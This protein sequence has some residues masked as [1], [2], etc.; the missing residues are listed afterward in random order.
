RNI[1][2]E[3]RWAEGRYERLPGLAADLVGHRVAVIAATGGLVTA[4]AAKAATTTIPV[5]FIAGFDPVFE[6]LVMSIA[7]PGGNATGVSIY[8][9]ELGRKRLE[10]LREI[11]PVNKVAML[12]NPDSVS[13]DIE[14]NDLQE[15]IRDPHLQL[16]VVEARTDRDLEQA[17]EQ[18]ARQGVGALMVSAD[19]F[20][21]SRRERI[22]E[23]AAR[24]KLPASYPWPQYAEAGGFL[25]YGPSLTSA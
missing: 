1:A 25:T 2:I 5:L 12:V 7:R 16:V 8:S 18:A 24:Y 15:G 11:V 3:Y 9:A 21:T 19:S 10:L 17:F 23:L 13:T 4:K 20:F 6:G 14:I 22:V